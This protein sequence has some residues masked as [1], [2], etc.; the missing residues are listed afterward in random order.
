[1]ERNDFCLDES[2]EVLE[3]VQSVHATSGV[4]NVTGFLIRDGADETTIG[5]DYGFVKGRAFRLVIESGDGRRRV[6][7]DHRGKPKSS[8]PMISSMDLGSTTGRAALRKAMA[9]MPAINSSL[10]R[11]SGGG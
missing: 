4:K 10:V 1:M 9:S 2:E 7:Y 3:V 5:S 11:F 8:Y 6:Y